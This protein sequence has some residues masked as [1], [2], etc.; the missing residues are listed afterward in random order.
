LFGSK[1]R[2]DL[3][4]TF[5]IVKNPGLTIN[6]NEIKSKV[7]DAINK[8][9]SIEY[10]N[11]GDTFYFSELS[12]YVMNNLSPN[13]VSLLLVPKQTAQGFGSLFEIKSESDEIFVSAA[14]V[15]D[16]EIIDE[17]TATNLKALGNVVTSVS[18]STSGIQSSING[19]SY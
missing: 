3:Q 7:I 5:K 13:L 12:A 8:F 6:N 11:F 10:W 16:V 19:S 15:A 14:T 17:I 18:S 1:A 4:A 9:F 2:E